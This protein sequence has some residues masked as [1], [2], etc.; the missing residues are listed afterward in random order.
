[1][2]EIKSHEFETFLQRSVRDNRLFLIYGQDRGLVS[3]RAGQIAAKTGVSL[4]DPFSLIKLDGSDLQQSP[5]RLLDEV[6]TIGLFGGEKLVWLR[7]SGTEK[8]LIDSFTV[9]SQ[10]PPQASTVIIEAGDLKKGT[11]LRKLAE[12]AR[13]VIAVACYSDDARAVNALIDQELGQEN[14]RI[15]PAA[16]ERL[17]EALGGD[18]IASRNEIRKLALYCRGMSVIEEEH[19]MEIVGD[20]SAVSVDDAIDAVLKGDA[21]GLQHAIR[22][23]TASKT[24][25]F[26]VLQACLKQFQ[27]MDLM[28][29]E[30]DDKR[31]QP[32]QVVATLGRH[33]HFR[34]KPLIESAL[35][36]WTL[37][38]IRREL[39]R[40]QTAIFQSRARQSLEDSIAMQ[41]LLAITL[42]SARN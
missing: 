23:I 28:R 1:M 14:L 31:Q 38:A 27:L 6:N 42:Q 37:P 4:D 12:T 39:G 3:E 22:K 40:L 26:L 34:R 30:M 33:L 32:A 7:A 15:S 16:R 11:G 25:I 29:A 36:T 20:A 24:A 41:T 10:E 17:N 19:V 2:T 21:D 18:R 5:G 35:K 8:T 13:S 9:L